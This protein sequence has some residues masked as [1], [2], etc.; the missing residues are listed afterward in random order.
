[1]VE[2]NEIFLLAMGAG[3]GAV[4][5]GVWALIESRISRLRSKDRDTEDERL[6]AAL[7]ESYKELARASQRI[8]RVERAL[9]DRSARSTHGPRLEAQGPVESASPEASAL[10]ERLRDAGW[11][12]ETGDDEWVLL[13]CD[14][15]EKHV[16]RIALSG[17]AQFISKVEEFLASETC[18]AK[19]D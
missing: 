6:A 9:D 7:E 10:I 14:C 16:A 19:D 15:G 17:S 1:M 18:C 4:A 11:T 5:T 13:I 3:L 12:L 8:S 2:L